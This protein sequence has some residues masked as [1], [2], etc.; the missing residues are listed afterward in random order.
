MEKSDP[1]RVS[2]GEICSAVP[3]GQANDDSLLL[4]TVLV[5]SLVCAPLPHLV[6]P[7]S[8]FQT[9]DSDL[10]KN[11]VTVILNTSA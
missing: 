7:L 3:I 8:V 5:F 6:L 1:Q 10:L 11:R 4:E 9:W 2:L